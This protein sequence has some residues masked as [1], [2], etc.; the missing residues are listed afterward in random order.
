MQKLILVLLMQTF[1][2]PLV[3]SETIKLGLNRPSTG[4]YKT[5]G[6]AQEGGA[7]L[8]VEEINEAGGI[9]GKPVELIIKNSSSKPKKAIRN[10]KNLAEAGAKMLF[11]GSSSAVAIA[12]GKE[13][14]NHNLIYFGT[15]TYSNATTGSE[16]HSHMFRET[17]NAWMSAKVLSK[18]LNTYY[19]DKTFFYITADYTWGWSTE[20][21]LRTF[22]N[23]QNKD[24]HK[25]I[26]T[27]FPNPGLFNLNSALEEA[28]KAKPDV[29]VLVQFGK[30]MATALQK[31]TSLGLKKDMLIVV[32]SLTLGMAAEAGPTAIEGVIGTVPWNWRVPEKYNYDQGKAFVKKYAERFGT[33]PSSASASAYSIV[34]QYKDAV[35]RAGSFATDKVIQALEGHSYSLLKDKQQWRSFDH[36][37]LQTIY[38]VKG[39]PR[40][41]VLADPFRQDYFQIIDD[42]AG[43]KAARS[44][45]EWK[46]DRIEAGRPIALQ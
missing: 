18:Y 37:N 10:V 27:Q 17:T 15:L 1:I 3:Y 38:A 42:L 8:A 33:Y 5:Q 46:A 36:Q 13:A 24:A 11:G 6:L 19:K 2:I 20:S 7:S 28:K 12:A 45:E 9:L 22:T 21:S 26:L 23:T 31:A 32:P 40:A 44:F 16:G 30:D 25:S 29:L 41:T 14:K 35:E 4:A 39:K 43:D 34:Y